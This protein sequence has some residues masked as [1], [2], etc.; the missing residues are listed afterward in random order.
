MFSS[1]K[2]FH[3]V[4]IGAADV[5]VKQ[6]KPHPDPYRVCIERFGDTNLKPGNVLAFE[7]SPTGMYSALAADCQCVLV[8]D[9]QLD[10]A[11]LHSQPTQVIP[12]LMDFRPELFGLPP[13]EDNL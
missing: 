9:P 2:Y 10:L 1:D 7:D 5:D 11:K 13:F 3:H 8:P 4:V 6:N 12:S